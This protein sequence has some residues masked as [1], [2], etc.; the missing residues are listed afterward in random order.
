MGSKDFR[1]SYSITFKMKSWFTLETWKPAAER[2]F[3]STVAEKMIREWGKQRKVLMKAEKS[4]RT[5]H[6]CACKWPN[7]RNVCSSL[8]QNLWVVI[9]CYLCDYLNFNCFVFSCY[10]AYHLIRERVILLFCGLYQLCKF[11]FILLSWGFFICNIIL[12]L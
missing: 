6:S 3:G 10:F 2:L 11:G 4:K 5:L 9:K 7:M 1:L 12:V 8:G